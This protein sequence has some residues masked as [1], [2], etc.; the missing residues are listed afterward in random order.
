MSDLM[1]SIE[2]IVGGLAVLLTAVLALIAFG[3]E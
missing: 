1:E 2:Y 3:P